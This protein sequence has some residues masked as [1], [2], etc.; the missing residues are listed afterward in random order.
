MRDFKKYFP[1]AE[2]I[3]KLLHPFAE[4][5]LHD[6]KKNQ[7]VKIFNN[8]TQRQVGDS[9]CIDDIK[10]K[11][12]EKGPDIHGP[13]KQKNFYGHDIKYTTCV[14][15]ND[16]GKA[17]GLMCINFNIE[18]IQHIQNVFNLF[19]ETTADSSNLDELFNDDWENRINIFVQRFRKERNCAFSKLTTQDRIQ[20][21][22]SLHEAG[23]FRATNAVSYTAKILGVSRATIYNYLN[24]MEMNK[25]ET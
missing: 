10:S 15:R 12:F 7:I 23:A 20:L 13:F 25:P 2:S 21:V 5:V 9:S 22:H 18:G 14:L 17:I 16:D 24:T 3:A 19:L 1:I 11:G 6:V 8:F 4:V